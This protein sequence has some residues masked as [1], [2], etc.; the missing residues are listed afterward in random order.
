MN[1]WL[2]EW[3]SA[4]ACSRGG[5]IRRNRRYVEQFTSLETVISEAKK[6]KW[7]VVEIGDQIVVLCNDGDMRVHC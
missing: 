4:Q 1:A 3:F 7:H 6:R 2:R 5:I